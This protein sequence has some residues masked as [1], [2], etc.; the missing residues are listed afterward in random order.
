[1]ADFS[2]LDAGGTLLFVEETLR[3][4]RQME[5]DD[6][7]LAVR[8]ADLHAEDPKDWPAE[9]QF[10]GMARLVQVGGEGT[11]RVQDLSIAELAVSRQTH[12]TATRWSLADGFDLVHRLPKVWEVLGTLQCESWLARRVARMTRH[13][14][15]EEAAHVDAA[16]AE[17]LLGEQPS[18]V[19]EI[20]EAKIIE[21]NPALHEERTREMRERRFVSLGRMDSA[22]L[23]H[24]IARVENGDA[25]WVDAM[26]DR[27]ADILAIRDRDEERP[28][29]SEDTR[30]AEA[31][32]WLGR[33]AELLALLLEHSDESDPGPVETEQDVVDDQC[34][35][36]PEEPDPEPETEAEPDPPS[37][38]DSWQ[39]GFPARLLEAL[40]S[41]DPAKLRPRAVVYVHLHQ[42][43]LASSR[44]TG[45]GAVVK[46]EDGG[47]MLPKNLPELLGKALVQVTEV[48]DLNGVTPVAT[49]VHPQWLK[50]Q[51][52]LISPRTAYPFSTTLSRRVDYDHPVPYEHGAFGEK[53]PPDQ[54]GLHNSAPLG[55][56]QHRVKT[57][58]QFTVR[59]PKP[60][61]YVWRTPHKKFF[62]V[63]ARGTHP[64][65]ET[66]GDAL[67][68]NP[69]RMEEQLAL[70]LAE[71]A[72]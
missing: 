18:V 30:R 11:P 56:Y 51:V 69:S 14:S 19:L 45:R 42:A 59:E 25:V 4:R 50:D 17:A 66:L 29:R 36:N 20:C 53:A 23:R 21:A 55:R 65:D 64:I 48:V 6:L 33:P 61:S 52:Q 22:G 13:L 3:Q 31:F 26:V 37:R 12:P 7:V 27:V 40:R 28:A 8:W 10:P 71:H 67:I 38:A 15:P 60:G 62:L 35:A 68:D 24:M 9:R 57:H 46:V 2:D 49:Y 54:T 16:V 72:A 63:D 70:V 47:P 44:P 34:P 58:A 39:A 5:Y 43:A 1:M 41:I 32:G